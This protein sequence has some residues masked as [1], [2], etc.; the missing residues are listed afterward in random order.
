[1][2][3]VRAWQAA[4]PR[5]LGASPPIP[6]IALLALLHTQLAF[7]PFPR[8]SSSVHLRATSFLVGTFRCVLLSPSPFL[9]SLSSIR[10]HELSPVKSRS[11]TFFHR[12]LPLV[13]IS[14]SWDCAAF[15]KTFQSQ[16]LCWSSRTVKAAYPCQTQTLYSLPLRWY[17]LASL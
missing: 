6:F 11:H 14:F 5:M 4:S 10:Y 1:M 3:V 13:R 2:G 16:C 17:P 12:S 15:L 8:Q 7:C 9:L